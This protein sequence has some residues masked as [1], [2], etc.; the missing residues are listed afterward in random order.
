ML[1]IIVTTKYAADTAF[2]GAANLLHRFLYCEEI[3]RNTHEL[4]W[5]H[6]AIETAKAI[7]LQNHA[8][9]EFSPASAWKNDLQSTDGGIPD[10]SSQSE[11]P[12]P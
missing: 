2:L 9:S 3:C 6:V 5:E 10:W 8:F 7:F 1:H 4:N 12:C 11:H